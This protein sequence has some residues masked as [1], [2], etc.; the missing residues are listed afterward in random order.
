MKVNFSTRV[1]NH[2]REQLLNLEILFIIVAQYI[3]VSAYNSDEYHVF[4]KPYSGKH[5]I[6]IWSLGKL[7][8]SGAPSKPYL[9]LGI[10]HE[11]GFVWD[12]QWCPKGS[13]VKQKVNGKS[14]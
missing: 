3:A 10:A 11:G 14:T 8:N 5:I 9:A 2:I 13:V 12:L 6:Q 1:E 4:S 7:T